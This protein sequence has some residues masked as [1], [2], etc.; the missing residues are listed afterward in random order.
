MSKK[1]GKRGKA[2]RPGS[3]KPQIRMPAIAADLSAPPAGIPPLPAD[4]K[5]PVTLGAVLRGTWN[6]I[7]LATLTLWPSVALMMRADSANIAIMRDNVV[8]LGYGAFI[9]WLASCLAAWKL[10]VLRGPRDMGPPLVSVFVL[11]QGLVFGSL[12]LWMLTEDRDRQYDLN[13]RWSQYLYTM[14]VFFIRF[15]P[16]G[17]AEIRTPHAR[18]PM[19]Y[20]DTHYIPATRFD[21]LC[22]DVHRGWL[23]GEWADLPHRCEPRAGQRMATAPQLSPVEPARVRWWWQDPPP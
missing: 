6:V 15:N 18:V 8:V 19:L 4:V 14:P 9:G 20:Y 5:Q 3:G 1:N 10:L 12:G 11:V 22:A 16:Q 23:G 21:Q 17:D 7:I 13:R 2:R